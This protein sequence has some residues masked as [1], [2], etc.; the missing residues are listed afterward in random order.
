VKTLI[1]AVI[2]LSA[3]ACIAGDGGVSSTEAVQQLSSW[4]GLPRSERAD[5]SHS[6]F[7]TVALTRS[8]A[9]KALEMLW[10]DH[11][12]FIRETRRAEMQSKVIELGGRKM[13]FE[14][15][16]F[17]NEPATNGRSL[18]ISMH[19]GGNAAP[20]VNE[21][22]WRNQIQ[23]GKSY[24]P[25]EGIYLAPRA[26]TD[27]W[28]L[29]HEAHIDDFFDRLIENLV[30]FSNVNPE[31]VYLMGYS[32]G[33]DGVYQLAPRMA[34]RFAGAAMMGGHPNDA[35]PLGLRNLP[36]A[37]QV[38]ANDSAY[39]RNQVAAEWG[40]KLDELQKG[41]PSGYV[42]FTELHAGKPH[43]MDLEDRKAIPWMEKYSRVSLPEKV[44]W[45]QSNRTHTR[46]YWL[47]GDA[48]KGGQEVVAE[49]RGPIVMLISPNVSAVTVLF[50]DRMMDLDKSVTIRTD[51]EMLF[52][53]RVNR[54][55]GTL[56][57]TL[58][59]RGDTNLVF[60]AEMAVKLR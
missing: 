36:F 17:T 44:V 19:G 53:G 12:A 7:A 50:N 15:V 34:D 51:S 40:K 20:S 1:T 56:A 4:L 60:S 37:I 47:A 41:D 24:A 35:S 48:V 52:E 57:R 54:T 3:I 26:P 29:W 16:S 2:L 38:G 13:K 23:L 11:T 45:R 55:I 31:R 59:E 18:F 6:A 25:R 21:S 33:G 8:D 27:T 58:A 32:A 22:Q 43:W 46:F 39:N 14:M 49:R 28:N 42:H 5:L 30:V 9:D 10:A